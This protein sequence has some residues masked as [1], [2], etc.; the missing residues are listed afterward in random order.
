[1]NKYEMYYIISVNADE[2]EREQI[3]KT[4]SDI[5]TTNGGT[6]DKLDRQGIKKFAYPIRDKSEGYYVLMNFT[7]DPIVLTEIE[8]K[9]SITENFV[10]KMF[11]K[12]DK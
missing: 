12:L 3:I 9:M 11:L 4:I 10:R 1:M 5:V 8:Q 6:V 2:T 7:A